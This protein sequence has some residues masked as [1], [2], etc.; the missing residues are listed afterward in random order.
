AVTPS[1][2]GSSFF[3]HL[4]LAVKAEEARG[5]VR[6]L[7]KLVADNFRGNDA[8]GDAVAAEVESEN[9]TRKLRNRSDVSQP[10]FGFPE[11]SGPGNVYLKIDPRKHFAKTRGELL[12][13]FGNETIAVRRIAKRN[14]LT[15]HDGA[16]IRSCAQVKIRARR[17]PSKT[18]LPP[19]VEASE[20]LAG[21]SERAG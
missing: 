16:A 9:I 19:A 11:G 13:L 3:R 7:Q 12:S 14:I 10:I 6:P 20:R 1:S 18:L 5:G 2:S 17:F 15:S 8:V 4:S 21:K